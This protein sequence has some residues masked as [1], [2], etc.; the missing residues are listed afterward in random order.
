[1][2]RQLLVILGFLLLINSCYDKRYPCPSYETKLQAQ[3]DSSGAFTGG[4]KHNKDKKTGLIRKKKTRRLFDKRG[5]A[6][7]Y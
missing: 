3:Y 7:L 5:K 1:M 4:Y 2:G 6:S